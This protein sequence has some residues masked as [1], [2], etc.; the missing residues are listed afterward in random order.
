IRNDEI[1]DENENG[2]CLNEGAD[3]DDKVQHVPTAPRLVRVD[4][5]RHAQ[6]SRNVHYIKREVEADQE[7]PEMP[8]T[9][10]LPQHPASQLRVPVIKRAKG[11]KQNSAHDHVVKMRDDKIGKAQLPIDRHRRLYDAGETCDQELKQ[12]SNAE[13]HG[14]LELNFSAP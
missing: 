4:A 10:T 6:Q 2:D 1:R 11:G 9:Q 3:R 12:K 13:Q 14:H 8:F 7:Q 5:T